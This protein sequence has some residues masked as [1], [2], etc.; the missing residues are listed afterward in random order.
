MAEET[1]DSPLGSTGSPPGGIKLLEDA[2]SLILPFTGARVPLTTLSDC[3]GGRAWPVAVA[4][5]SLLVFFLKGYND[6]NVLRIDAGCC[7]AL[8]ESFPEPRSCNWDC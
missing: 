7:C 6:P 2:A 3:E 5:G 8:G 4:L 1:C